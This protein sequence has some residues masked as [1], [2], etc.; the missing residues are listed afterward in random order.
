MFTDL[1]F[2][3]VLFIGLITATYTDLKRRE[4]P[5]W[6]NYFLIAVGLVGHLIIS[7]FNKSIFPIFISIAA[8]SVFFI[9]ANVLFYSGSWG[10]GDTK[11]LV[12]L[13][14]L[15]PQYP[16]SL[17]N[18][19]SPQLAEWPFLVTI[20]FN[21]LLFGA[22]IGILF[23]FYSAIRNAEKV[24]KNLEKLTK[25][26]YV[27]VLRILLFFLSIPLILGIIKRVQN[28]SF[29]ISI[30]IIFVFFFYVLLISFSIEDFSMIKKIKPLN[31]TEG[32]WIAEDVKIGNKIVYKKQ[33][34]GIEI[35]D[36]VLLK[37]LE[38]EGKLNKVL[39]K[40]GLPFLPSFLLGIVFT[41]IIGD[42]M[43]ILLSSII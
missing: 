10:G 39:I 20:F 41:L 15:L 26:T 38:S 18:F 14:A 4:V 9:V 13:G 1:F 23:T 5:D 19:L 6:I 35:K 32:D 2:V 34:I 43:H 11:F 7:I 30:W 28:I 37:K 24:K 21:I 8:A 40:E 16:K 25:K 17:L 3:I 36:I 27:R 29:F 42:I 12:A 31:L 33:R 22:I